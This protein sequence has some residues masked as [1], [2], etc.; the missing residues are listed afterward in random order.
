MGTGYKIPTIKG[1]SSS[2]RSISRNIASRIEYKKPINI[3]IAHENRLDYHTQKA[4][5]LADWMKQ[6]SEF[7]PIID[8]DY[9]ER[10]KSYSP[11]QIDKIERNMV[12][13]TDAV[14]RLIAPSSK[15]G[16]SRHEGPLREYRKSMR[17]RK[18]I[19]EIFYQGAHDSPNRPVQEKNYKYRIVI[20][21][22]RGEDLQKAIKR[23]WN[24]YLKIK[25][26]KS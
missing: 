14:V 24:E 4:H 21:K 10:N 18:P 19:I 23:G 5:R 9:F 20:H 26:Q 17:V 7:N 13:M 1:K 22:K 2:L 6:T 16:E 3:L 12:K 15:T 8:K 11:N 25:E